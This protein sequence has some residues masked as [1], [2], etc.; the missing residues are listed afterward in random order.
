MCST[1][2]LLCYLKK[3]Y[4]HAMFFSEESLEYSSLAGHILNSLNWTNFLYIL[5]EDVQIKMLK[6][7]IFNHINY[8][9]VLLCK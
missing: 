2:S 5:T 3:K 8:I 1:A 4:D 9:H 6:I 7:S